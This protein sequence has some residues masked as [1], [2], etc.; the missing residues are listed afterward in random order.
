M[1]DYDAIIAGASFAGL[2]VADN[3]DG[4]ILL[5]DRK[6][7]GTKQTSACATFTSVLEEV[8][9]KNSILQEFD[10]LVLHIPEE[11]NVELVEPISTFDYEKY[12]KTIAGRLKAKILISP[13]NGVS[14]QTV[15]TES[16]NFNSECIIDCTGWRAVL[17]SSLGKGYVSRD[18]LVFGIESEVNYADDKLHFFIDPEIIPCGAAWIFPVGS[19]S[20][21]GLASYA[22]KTEILQQLTQFLKGMS[23]DPEDVHGG[24]IPLGLREPVMGNV[25][26]VGDSAG[27]ATPTVGE[28]IRPTVYFSKECARIVQNIIDGDKTLKYGLG[29][30]RKIVDRKKRGYSMLMNMQGR[31]MNDHV[32][33]TIKK[34]ACSRIFSKLFQR[35]YI[36]I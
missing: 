4:D 17:G 5:V 11:R 34:A 36:G 32:P 26:M 20:R 19:K 22:G 24:Y 12:C 10:T 7:I 25:F 6:E 29:E 21:I 1:S 30:Y 2:T 15:L 35:M 33:E 18:K 13:V 28:G 3:I 16:G 9:C 27:H 14:G 31:L 8:G 23:L